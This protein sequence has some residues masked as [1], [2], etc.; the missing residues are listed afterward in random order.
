MTGSSSV[1]RACSQ[2]RC[3]DLP[4]TDALDTT[5]D[6]AERGGLAHSLAAIGLQVSRTADELRALAERLVRAE[7]EAREADTRAAT[8][9]EQAEE[10]ARKHA[11]LLEMVQ[12]ARQGE[13]DAG[14]RSRRA[15]E[16]LAAAESRIRESEADAERAMAALESRL[17]ESEANAQEALAAAESKL[18][19]AEAGAEEALAAAES[20]LRDAEANAKLAEDRLEL[21]AA[22]NAELLALVER[23]QESQADGAEEVRRI[24]ERLGVEVERSQLLEQQLREL[25][26]RIEAEDRQHLT[27]IV[28]DEE[29]SALHEAV[30]AEVRR[31]LTSILGLT[32]A[33]KHTEA[34]S[35]DGKDMVKQLATNA[36]KL[37]RLVGQML[38]LD[39]IA[40]GSFVPNRRRTDLEAMV[41]RVIEES[42]DLAKRDVRIEAQ[43]AATPVD[44]QLAEQM[45]DALLA[46]AGKRAAPGDP[47]WVKI[48]SE[49]GGVTIA[50][51]DTGPDVPPGLRSAMFAA[52]ADEGPRKRP[53]GATGLSLLARLAEI[54][55]GRAWVEER[56]GGGASFRVFLAESDARPDGD[57][58]QADAPSAEAEDA[59]EA[60]DE[61]AP[62]TN[63][64]RKPGKDPGAPDDGELPDIEALRELL[65][66]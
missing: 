26:E 58:P 16:A 52:L 3:G 15:E 31:P 18:G 42:Q 37:D 46:N 43:R 60:S 51:D 10:S 5:E 20:R 57:R 12:A 49:P 36:R 61:A 17:R 25:G 13:S 35:P 11:E 2:G 54:H 56:P 55:G 48:S 24:E 21:V 8:A 66:S 47:V 50:V 23:S 39:K 7:A 62:E 65:T 44:P 1:D 45:I 19:E 4:V 29:R 53:K 30:A 64:H 32:L 63:G 22:Q 38:E 6:Q 33:L 59:S 14:E 27:V 34:S 9:G 28:N 40:N 41:R